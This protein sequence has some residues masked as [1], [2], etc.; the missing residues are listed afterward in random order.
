MC[1]NSLWQNTTKHINRT[2]YVNI[3][4]GQGHILHQIPEE[5]LSFYL[6]CSRASLARIPGRAVKVELPCAQH[7]VGLAGI[8]LG[9]PS[10]YCNPPPQ[11]YFDTRLK[12]INVELVAEAT[13]NE[14]RQASIWMSAPDINPNINSLLSVFRLSL[15]A[16]TL[17]LSC[18]GCF[19]SLV[20][21]Y[22]ND[23]RCAKSIH[24]IVLMFF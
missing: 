15:I 12:V 18:L 6:T 20:M 1:S 5:V 24:G 11:G 22:E 3:S 14:E 7:L 2:S 10:V 23:P 4:S 19:T 9:Y 8:F 21:T 16:P 13:E 17:H